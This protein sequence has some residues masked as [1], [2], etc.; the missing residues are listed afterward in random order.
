MN[1]WNS[2]AFEFEIEVEADVALF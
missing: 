2:F 1:N